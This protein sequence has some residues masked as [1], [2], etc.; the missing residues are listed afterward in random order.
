MQEPFQGVEGRRVRR[1]KLQ[2]AE[3][4]VELVEELPAVLQEDGDH[5]PVRGEGLEGS[6]HRL[7]LGLRRQRRGGG[8]FPGSFCRGYRSLES[9]CREDIWLGNLC[10]RSLCLRSL[11]LRSLCLKPLSLPRKPL[12]QEAPP[13]KLL[14]RKPLAQ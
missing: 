11:C 12:A 4:G 6:F 8:L 10:L 5:L 2:R 7:E 9:L 14:P 1:S 3:L 13:R